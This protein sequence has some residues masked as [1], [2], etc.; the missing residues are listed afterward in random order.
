MYSHMFWSS[1]RS[2]R[3]AVARKRVPG[4]KKVPLTMMT[5]SSKL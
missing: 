3:K 2:F 4:R 5:G 1:L